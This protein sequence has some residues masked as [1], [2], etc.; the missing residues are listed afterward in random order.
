MLNIEEQLKGG[1][2]VAK[3]EKWRISKR[4]APQR[5]MNAF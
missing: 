4:A 1:A 3:Y 5:N 2:G